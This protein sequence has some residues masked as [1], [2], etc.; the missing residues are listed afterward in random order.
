MIQCGGA[1]VLG[2]KGEVCPF[3]GLASKNKKNKYKK[4][5]AINIM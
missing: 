3:P 4:K 1:V 2:R 5:R